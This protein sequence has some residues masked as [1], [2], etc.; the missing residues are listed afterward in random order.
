MSHSAYISGVPVPERTRKIA[1]WLEEWAAFKPKRADSET[2]RPGARLGVADACRHS[3]LR[4]LASVD[5]P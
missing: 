2:R 1:I 4:R 3:L 5:P